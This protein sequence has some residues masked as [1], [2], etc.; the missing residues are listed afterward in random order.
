LK[1]EDPGIVVVLTGENYFA[2][3]RCVDIGDGVL[4]GIPASK[5]KIEPAHERNLAID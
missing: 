3:V 2:Q 1:I 5:A 4:I